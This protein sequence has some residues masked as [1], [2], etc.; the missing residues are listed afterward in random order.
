MTLLCECGH[1]QKFHEEDGCTDKDSYGCRCEC[2]AFK[3]AEDDD[4]NDP[5]IWLKCRSCEHL[6]S[7]HADYV[8]ECSNCN[9]KE[10]I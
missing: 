10:M 3:E 9:C 6:D 8:G 4:E 1:W 5:S 2:W 7:A